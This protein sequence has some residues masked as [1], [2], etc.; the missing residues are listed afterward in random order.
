MANVK[1][2]KQNAEQLCTCCGQKKKITSE[3]FYK[4]YSVLYKSNIDNR[5]AVCKDCVLELVEQFK[6]RFNSDVRAL[7]EICKLL[8]VYYEFNLYNSALAQVEKSKKK[9]NPYQI[10]FQKALS[11]PQYKNKTFIDSE[12][13]DKGKDDENIS[14]EIG[15]DLVDFWGSGLSQSDYD[16]L[17]KEYHNLTTRYECDSYSQEVLF[18]EIANQRLDIKKKRQ[19]SSSVDKELKT[20]QDLL[21]SANIKPVQESNALASEQVTFGTLIKKYEN[22][23]PI[24]EPLGEWKDAD[25][26]KK[27]VLTWF[28]GHFSKMMGAKNKYSEMYEDEIKKYTVSIEHEEDE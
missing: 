16:F 19:N 11:L 17:E 22:E 5:M 13:F 6:L 21:G 12:L 25:W 28:L 9:S 4:S 20:L 27:Y 14:E 26:I 3:Y 23:K 10:Y 2:T 1:T 15:R 24:P 7:Y 8:D 18:Q